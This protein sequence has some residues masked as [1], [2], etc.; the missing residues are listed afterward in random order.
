MKHIWGKN[1]NEAFL[2]FFFYFKIILPHSVHL[3]WHWESFNP[4]VSTVKQC[5][6]QAGDD[7]AGEDGETRLWW[8]WFSPL[9][10]HSPLSRSPPVTT[11]KN[12]REVLQFVENWYLCFFNAKYWERYLWLI[13]SLK[14]MEMFIF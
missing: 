7:V 5:S 10:L 4:T 3:L 14:G 12:N 2:Y 6:S 13:P 9:T 11:T 8:G 1:V